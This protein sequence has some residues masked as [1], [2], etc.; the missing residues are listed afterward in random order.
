MK[1][2]KNTIFLASLCFGFGIVPVLS[3]TVQEVS[4]KNETQVL[5]SLTKSQMDSVKL[6]KENMGHLKKMSARNEGGIALTQGLKDSM[7]PNKENISK[8]ATSSAKY[9]SREKV[10]TMEYRIDRTFSKEQ[11]NKLVY[12]INKKHTAILSYSNVAYNEKDEIVALKLDLIDSRLRTSSYSI[13]PGKYMAPL[14]IY[15]Y[16]DG[17]SGIKPIEMDAAEE[18]IP[19][20]VL[21][22]IAA[23]EAAEKEREL[24]RK[25]R[26]NTTTTP[27]SS[28][29]KPKII[30]RSSSTVPD[31]LLPKEQ[32]KLRKNN[33]K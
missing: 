17:R 33:D 22:R 26:Q 1:N 4:L 25:Q 18:P 32:Q 27:R 31:S 24:L 5:N 7:E 10:D 15:E 30:V 21:E 9:Q 29:K 3:Q 14:R 8:I 23:Q 11:L 2:I 16:P 12:D 19:A 28:S 13:E 6:R 20:A